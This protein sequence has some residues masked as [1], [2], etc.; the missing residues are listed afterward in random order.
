MSK[1]HVSQIILCV[2]LAALPV[3]SMTAQERPS[4]KETSKIENLLRLVGIAR[5]PIQLR[6]TSTFIKGN[7]WLITIDES[8]DNELQQITSDGTYHSPLWIPGSDKILTLKG[9]KLIQLDTGEG[10]EKTL[11]TLPG[12]TILV[13]FDQRDANS[14]LTLQDSEPAM[15]SLASGQIMLLPYEDSENSQDREVLDRLRS[16]VSN[17]RDYGDI[18]VHV[19]S[20]TLFV[21]GGH[22]EIN[23]IHIKD[24]KQDI[25]IP[26]P[27]NCVQPTLSWDRKKLVFV[28]D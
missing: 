22:E 23:K 14:I 10:E 6:E 1:K 24:G 16:S 5:L 20:K 4:E 12:H 28:V 9:D 19:S 7:L 3:H 27:E 13:G 18:K 26:C 2:V 17:Y 25:E 8:G 21:A 15:L 11:H